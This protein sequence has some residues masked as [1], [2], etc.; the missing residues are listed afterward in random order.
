[1]QE[2]ADGTVYRGLTQAELDAQYDQRTAVPHVGEYAARWQSLSASLRA[3]R[4]CETNA[5]GPSPAERLDLYPG[6]GADVHLHIHGGAWT[7]LS[8]QEAAFTVAGLGAMAAQ[9]AVAGF[10]LAPQTRLPAMV[11]QIRRAFLWLRTHAG[12]P[13]A[14]S[15]HSSGAHLAACLLD[16]RWWV[17]E[18]L[19]PRDFAAVLLASGPYDLEPVRLSAR[20][21]Y[22]GLSRDEAARLSP[23]L[24]LPELLPPMAVIW[25]DGELAEFRRQSEAMATAVRARRPDA[26]VEMLAG[27]NHFDVYDDFGDPGSRVIEHLRVTATA[28]TTIRT[29]Q[30]QGERS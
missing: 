10:G 29:A 8:R 16:R 21:D 30:R 15:G 7:R 14:V 12:A 19:G 26:R 27:R 11:A 6:A 9:V 5:Y 22:L 13:I 18:G 17:A 23:I 20:N 28:A 1:L 24:H 4:P 25:G 2:R 3:E